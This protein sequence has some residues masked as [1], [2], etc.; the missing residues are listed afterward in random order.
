M[1][2]FFKFIGGLFLM[3]FV[4][5]ACSIDDDPA[6]NDFF[7]GKYNGNVSYNDANVNKQNNNGS[8]QVVKVG[9]TYNFLFSD[10]IPDITGVEIQ[11][12]ENSAVMI[13]S[14]TTHYIKINANNLTILFLK[15]GATWTADANR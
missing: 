13:G 15:D 12:N 7:I 6:N 9:N 2:N 10:E 4:V 5:T 1:R 11:K 8:V 14:T 3:V